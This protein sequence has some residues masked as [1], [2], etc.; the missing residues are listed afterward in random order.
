MHTYTVLDA[1]HKLAPLIP[2]GPLVGRVRRCSE[3]SLSKETLLIS[4]RTGFSASALK[5]QRFLLKAELWKI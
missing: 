3:L 4:V 5:H 1:L 2:S